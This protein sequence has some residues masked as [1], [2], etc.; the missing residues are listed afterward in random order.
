[1]TKHLFLCWLVMLCAVITQAQNTTVTG[2]VAD[3]KGASVPFATISEIGTINSVVTD[4]SGRFSITTRQGASLAATSAGFQGQTLT[5]SGSSL[6]F[7]L[8]SG[9]GNLQEVVVTALGI[10]RSR[11]QV[12]YAAQQITGDEV[13]RNRSNNFLQN[14]S[15]RISGLEI[16]QGNTLG[17]STN[18]VIRGFKS[19]GGTN[20][21]LFVV[22]GVP[23]DN[24]TINSGDQ[25]T[26]RGGY[27][28]GNAAADINPDDIESVTVLKGAAAT[29]LYGSRAGNGV[30]LI[31]TKKG[32]RSL[33]ITINSG[34][35][36]GSIDKST[37]VK[38]QKQ[39][40]GGYGAYY[41]DP[42]SRFLY[43]DI[44]GDGVKDLVTPTSEDASYGGAFDPNLQVYQWDA[45]DPSS[46]YYGKSRP[47]VAAAN[48]PSTFFQHSLSSN[49]SVFVNS[50]NDKGSFK[51]GFTR[52]DD[53]GIV[54]NS[55]QTKN[56]LDF[57]ATYNLTPALTAGA[58]L[59]YSN[60][61]AK[62]RYGTGYTGYGNVATNFRQWWQTNVDVKELKDAYFRNRNNVTW[63]WADP[64]DLT[65]IY[66]NNP[67]WDRYENYESDSRD[68]IFGNVNATYKI[69]NWL[70][71]LG[72]VSI[73]RW[74]QLTEERIAVGSVDVSNYNRTNQTFQELNFD[75]LA[76]MEK[77][78]SK[79]FLLRGL[80]GTNIRRSHVE[81][82]AAS[83]NGG[84]TTP[85][86]Y[87]LSNSAN[88]INIPTEASADL[89]VDGVFAGATV[90]W[91]NMVTLDGTIRRDQTTTL[92]ANNN[93]YYYPSGSV[94]FVFSRLLATTPW[95]SYGKLR[96][97]YAQVGNGAPANSLFDVYSS[98][99]QFGSQ[100]QYSVTGTKN[101]ANLKPELTK[102]SEA[103]VEMQ[104]L[105]N[106][107]GFDVTYYNALSFNQ[108]LPVTVS[109]ATGYSS[110][111]VNAGNIRNKG[112]EV[113]LTGTPVQARNFS[114]NVT[115]N[116]TRNR[117]KVEALYADPTTGNITDNLV[118]GSFQGG[119][120]LNATLN[121]PYGTIRGSDFIYTN[122][123]K[124]V[125]ANGRYLITGTSNSVI[126]NPN[127][128]W[129]AGLSNTVR[130]RDL[131]LS[132]LLDMRQGGDLFSLDM[133]Y[134]LAT[135]LYPET[136]GNNDLGNPSRNSL[137]NGGGI[138]LNGVTAD[139]KTN[140]KR[141]S[142][143][144]YGTYG[145]V[146]NPAKAF[147]YDASYLKLREVVLSYALPKTLVGKL[148]PFKGIDISVIGRNLW[149]IH[150][151]LPYAD[152]EEI[153]SA[154]N[155]QGYQVGAYPTNRTLA[156]NLRL[157]F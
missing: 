110:L 13:S 64:T 79:D 38:Y 129:I 102:S 55:T 157:R 53:K 148:N 96:V 127:P 115:L 153:I 97:N 125:G 123:Q 86:F 8:T 130:Y 111:Y 108:I 17:S 143:S 81:S 32:A 54:A 135:G 117:N 128:D 73:D 63:N 44:N 10:R 77:N 126:G 139:G 6:N 137:A 72:R 2:R 70:N 134:G 104:F 83:T 65:P 43:R 155:L 84:L 138:I 42:T 9:Q 45:F 119:V 26:G 15:G 87:A 132:W 56:L 57:G 47:W 106:R 21:A 59:N 74:N 1:M 41:E 147:V 19:I 52:T 36:V 124:T 136:A 151:N 145:Y 121:Q 99:P 150:K 22:D 113:S 82:I 76:N 120:T 14:I 93:S 68:R 29:A 23:F 69:T 33:G 105:K 144:N 27:D 39:Y 94:G 133:Y 31:T 49:Q 4:S 142:N 35:G 3:E 107:V 152:P 95:I 50:G 16:R 92:P 109:T 156:F 24:S 149:L 91:R 11:N 112:I 90:S 28:Y 116:W 7:Q 40:G 85:R 61:S 78:L 71:V 154:G 18:A 60:V 67:Y 75:L 146:Y 98:V 66:W 89:E 46:P 141:V 48:D 62:G 131:S 88:P 37:F 100:A 140:T 30:I 122:G 118:L 58:T 103:G 20:Q 5:V 80:I 12:P 25:R 34:I 114:W 51:L 101:N